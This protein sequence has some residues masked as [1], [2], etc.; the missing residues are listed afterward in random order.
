MD[1]NLFGHA[2]LASPTV[3]PIFALARS[4]GYGVLQTDTDCQLLSIHI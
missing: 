2:T 1:A 3:F 4:R